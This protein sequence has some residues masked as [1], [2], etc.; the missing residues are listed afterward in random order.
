MFDITKL[1]PVIFHLQQISPNMFKDTGGELIIHCPFCD[2]ALRPNALSHGH[3]YLAKNSP[4]FNCFR[5]NASGTLVKFLLLT[6]FHD[7]D[8][9]AYISSFVKFNFSKE[10]HSFKTKQ[11]LYNKEY[12]EI[13]VTN[14]IL[15]FAEEYPKEYNTYKKY[16]YSRIGEINLIPFLI[17]PNWVS[18]KKDKTTSLACSFLNSKLELT[19]SRFINHKFFRY[20]D[21]ECDI[22]YYFQEKNFEKYTTICMTEGVFD[23]LNLYIYTNYFDKND[24][25]WV[26]VKGKK[27]LSAIEQLT[28]QD[29]LLGQY[30]IHIIFDQDVQY[31]KSFLFK[32][33]MLSSQFNNS[34]KITGWKPD[35]SFSDPGQYPTIVEV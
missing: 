17:Y 35:V 5:C 20:K 10:Y 31:Y 28:H 27:F 21:E 30:N 14:K 18:P 6:D 25:F 34:I 9:F 11:V 4:V 8:V 32:A 26:A 19:T 1:S 7:Q 2:D 23:L 3:C 15:K 29:L 13:Q 24:T 16:L 12:N 22:G 33:N